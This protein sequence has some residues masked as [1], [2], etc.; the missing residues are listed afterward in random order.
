MFVAK[1]TVSFKGYALLFI[2][3]FFQYLYLLRELKVIRKILDLVLLI[4]IFI[5]E[6]DSL[7]TEKIRLFLSQI[8]FRFSAVYS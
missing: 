7:S 8:V 1:R 3:F 6:I 4:G 2:N 5:L